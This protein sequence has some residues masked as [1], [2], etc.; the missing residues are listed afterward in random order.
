MSQISPVVVDVFS[1]IVSAMMV[2]KPDSSGYWEI[3]FNCGRYNQ[4]IKPLIDKDNSITLKDKKYPLVALQ[5]PFTED[6]SSTSFDSILRV[7]RI[8]LATISNLTDD[9][10]KRYETDGT[11]KS[12]LIPM[13]EEF[14][15]QIAISKWTN[16]SDPDAIKHRKRDSPGV[17]PIGEGLSDYVDIIEILNLEIPLLNIKN[18]N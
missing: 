14:L 7:P 17:Q 1:D 8:V 10:F 2:L 11:F 3:Q 16:I 13:Y 9:V 18:C 5:M 6:R 15:K 12:I 4:I